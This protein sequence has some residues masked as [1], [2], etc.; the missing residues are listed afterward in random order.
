MTAKKRVDVASRATFSLGK[1]YF[2]Y[3]RGEMGTIGWGLKT[4]D[5]RQPIKPQPEPH[6]LRIIDSA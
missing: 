4:I 3:H 6:H 1:E 5:C 2:D